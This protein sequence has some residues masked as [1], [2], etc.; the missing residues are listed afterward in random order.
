M[1]SKNGFQKSKWATVGRARKLPPAPKHPPLVSS[2]LFSNT[3]GEG[4]RVRTET[5]CV[6]SHNQP[7]YS[8]QV[9]L[10]DKYCFL[11]ENQY[12]TP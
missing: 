2:L 12:S 10:E 6:V 7:S 3:R 5:M 11:L 4:S 9:E 8:K 1:K